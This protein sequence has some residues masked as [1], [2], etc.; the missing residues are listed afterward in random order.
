MSAGDRLR[1]DARMEIGIASES[2]SVSA[3]ATPVLQTD[4]STIGMLIATQS[5]ADLP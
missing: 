5:V 4:S 3:E 2:T 1:V